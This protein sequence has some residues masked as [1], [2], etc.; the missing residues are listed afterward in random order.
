MIKFTDGDLYPAVALLMPKES[1]EF[2]ED[3]EIDCSTLGF[4]GPAPEF[5]L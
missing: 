3:V 5:N 2:V 1:V 4:L